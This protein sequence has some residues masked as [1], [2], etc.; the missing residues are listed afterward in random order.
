[1]NPIPQRVKCLRPFRDRGEKK[2]SFFN[3][4]IFRF[5]R[6]NLTLTFNYI[7][8]KN[9]RKHPTASIVQQSSQLQN[10]PYYQKQKK[11]RASALLIESL[12]Y[13]IYYIIYKGAEK[14]L[15]AVYF[16]SPLPRSVTSLLSSVHEAVKKKERKGRLSS[17]SRFGCMP[18][19]PYGQGD[20]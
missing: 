1:M 19:S 7:L 2:S 9:S 5:V 6:C 17:G 15:L 13:Y 10:L 16:A 11:G 3:F 4:E 14:L 8:N 18:R 20:K 12:P